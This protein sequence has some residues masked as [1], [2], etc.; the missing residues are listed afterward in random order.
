MSGPRD[1]NEPGAG[2]LD[3]ERGSVD[4]DVPQELKDEAAQEA[5]YPPDETDEG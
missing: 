4:D 5:E 1:Q 2:A 3:P